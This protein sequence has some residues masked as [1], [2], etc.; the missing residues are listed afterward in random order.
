MSSEETPSDSKSI[1]GESKEDGGA[2]PAAAAAQSPRASPDTVSTPTSSTIWD[3][4]SNTE[5]QRHPLLQV[6]FRLFLENLENCLSECYRHVDSDESTDHWKELLG[7]PG[8]FGIDREMKPHVYATTRAR[9][10]IFFKGS[11]VENSTSLTKTLER[12]GVPIHDDFDV[13]TYIAVLQENLEH[14]LGHLKFHIEKINDPDLLVDTPEK[15]R[16][17]AGFSVQET[18][19]RDHGE[20]AG[21]EPRKTIFLDDNPDDES[22]D[23][24]DEIKSLMERLQTPLF[25]IFEKFKEKPSNRRDQFLEEQ[26]PEILSKES[27]LKHM[28]YPVRSCG[29]KKRKRSPDDQGPGSSPPDDPDGPGG[30]N[31]D[32]DDDDGGDRDPLNPPPSTRRIGRPW[33]DSV[34]AF[35]PDA[36][37]TAAQLTAV[38]KERNASVRVS[39]QSETTWGGHDPLRSRPTKGSID[40]TKKPEI[41]RQCYFVIKFCD[42]SRN[43]KTIFRRDEKICVKLSV[44]NTT[45]DN[46]SIGTYPDVYFE[47]GGVMVQI[48][49]MDPLRINWQR[50]RWLELPSHHTYTYF[51]ILTKPRKDELVP[52]ATPPP[53]DYTAKVWVD[54]QPIENTEAMFSVV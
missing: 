35:L 16:H 17:E 21:N 51:K 20:E 41:L 32:D 31:D 49:G 23:S 37:Q 3:S 26:C 33:Q 39:C 8:I 15:L 2:P 1:A 24:A 43:E 19:R 44:E 9:T 50:V 36:I 38:R 12:R 6:A 22:D 30:G 14:E 45:P 48:E 40:V 27:I 13:L 29:K 54:G 34:R 18:I 42:E 53:G 11:L 47:G 28:D 52:Y 5:L 4:I 46:I 7:L 25:P 10:G